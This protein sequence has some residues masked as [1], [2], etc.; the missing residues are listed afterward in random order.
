MAFAGNIASGA[1]VYNVLWMGAAV[2]G[3]G[4]GMVEDGA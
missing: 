3:R 1:Q 4:L 2:G